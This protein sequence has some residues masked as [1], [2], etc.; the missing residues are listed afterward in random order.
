MEYHLSIKRNGGL[1]HTTTRIN[2]VNVELSGSSQSHKAT[3]PD[4]I[5]MKVHNKEIYRD[6]K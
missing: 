6:R 2:L 3:C 4:S 5:H 1:I